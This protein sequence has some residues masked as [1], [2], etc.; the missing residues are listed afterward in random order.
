[1]AAAPKL[2]PRHIAIIMDGN[3]RWA[4]NRGLARIKGHEKGAMTPSGNTPPK[5]NDMPADAKKK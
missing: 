2:V 4:K 5:G 1:M 3:G